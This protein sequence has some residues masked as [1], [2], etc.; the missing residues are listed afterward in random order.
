MIRSSFRLGL[1]ALVALGGAAVAATANDPAAGTGGLSC[2]VSKTRDQGMLV[3]EGVVQS[4]TALSGDY[5]FSLRSSG[6][7]GSTNINQG[8]GF[9][10]P[11]GEP[12]AVGRV[13][14]GA[15]AQVAVDFTISTGGRTFDC[16]Q[17]IGTR[18]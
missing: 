6:G 13:M 1:V 3:V 7:G 5:R 2:G 8:G 12:V 15:N 11:S 18:I 17:D 9:M 16:S 10:L 4:P 14:V